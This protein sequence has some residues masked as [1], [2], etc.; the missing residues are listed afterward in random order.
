MPRLIAGNVKLHP[1]LRTLFT[2]AILAGL[3]FL[4]FGGAVRCNFVHFD[5]DIYVF[6]NWH[7]RQGLTWAGVRWAFT[8]AHAANWHP[9]TWLSHMADVTLYGLNPAGHHLSSLFFH[10]LNAVLLGRILRR[11]TGRGGLALAAAALWAVHPLRTESVVWISERKDV[12]AMFFGLL[13]VEAYGGG[14]QGWT[15]AF[16]AFSLM[17]KPMW[18]TLPFVLLLLDFW[19][20]RRWPAASWQTLVRE[21][22][23][24]F[25]LTAASGAITIYA[26]HAGGALRPFSTYPLA[27][28]MGNAVLAYGQYLRTLFWPFG[29]SFFHPYPTG[30]LPW[31][32]IGGLAILLLAM[33]IGAFTQAAKRPWWLVG[34]LWFL[35][36]LV[37]M[38]GLVQVGGAAWAERYTYLAHIGLIL[39]LVWGA[40][41]VLERGRGPGYQLLWDHQKSGRL[42]DPSLPAEQLGWTSWL[43]R[44]FLA[45]LVVGCI[46]LS[47]RQTAVWQDSES[48]FKHALAVQEDNA[49]AHANLGAWLATQGRGEEAQ[50]HLMRSLEIQ[51]I[52]TE[53]N[54]NLGNL[55][56]SRGDTNA[57][58]RCYRAMMA[59][60]PRHA[61]TLNN[62]AWLLA[63]DP[64]A[65]RAQAEEALALARRAIACATKPNPAYEDTLKKAQGAC[66]RSNEP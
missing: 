30:G 13:A 40:G 31:M 7:V 37:P 63:T 59:D 39:A 45:A 18:V 64:A 51:P 17:A 52:R 19:P 10:A 55:Y 62:L 43:G 48:L 47:R 49:L 50:R 32:R 4:A 60:N 41:E 25:L 58:I 22:W 54:F 35:G 2:A 21:K 24:V 15:A 11:L 34:G 66:A 57:A 8:T 53:A 36:S 3:V 14:R 12:L 9:L 33:T 27:I 38:I 5:D 28:R 46:W 16:Y 61:P 29:L 6:E 44:G 26:Q 1:R 23:L 20:L 42:V 65:S 56:L